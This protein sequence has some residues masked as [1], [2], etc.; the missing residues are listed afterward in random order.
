M[1]WTK[2]SAIAL[3]AKR[4]SVRS[5]LLSSACRG[6]KADSGQQF[7]K[8]LRRLFSFEHGPRRI[9][10]C[11]HWD[12]AGHHEDILMALLDGDRRI[13]QV[14]RAAGGF[15]VVEQSASDGRTWI[16]ERGL[17]T[18]H[19]PIWLL[20]FGLNEKAAPLAAFTRKILKRPKNLVTGVVIVI[21]SR[22]RRPTNSSPNSP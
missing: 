21:A 1:C 6:P 12:A 10:R 22:H 11:H 16:L 2:I 7:I 9:E 18:G 20:G 5:S 17:V 15:F 4:T 3:G 14:A 13:R 8:D 19:G